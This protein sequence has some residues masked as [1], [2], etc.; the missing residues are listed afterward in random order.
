MAGTSQF[1]P[2]LLLG[3]LS[4]E[5]IDQ[6]ESQHEGAAIR[7]VGIVGKK[8]QGALQASRCLLE[9]GRAASSERSESS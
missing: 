4:L 9:V 6:S 3:E 2:V 7:K 5:V 8:L 1:P